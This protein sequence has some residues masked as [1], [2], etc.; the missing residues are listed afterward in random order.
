MILIIDADAHFCASIQKCFEREQ[1]MALAAFTGRDG[2]EMCRK[3]PV[4]VVILNQSLPDMPGDEVCKAILSKNEN[5][6]IV[7]VTEQPNFNAAVKAIRAGAF[8]CLAKPCKLKELTLTV[9]RAL[10]MIDMEIGTRDGEDHD[11]NEDTR[12]LLIDGGGLRETHRLIDLAASNDV[13]V[14]ITGETGTGKN[15]VAK[16]IHRLGA[17]R[18]KPFVCINCAALPE[19]L[20]E[21]E[22]FGYE[23]GAFT[24]AN[25]R[26]RGIFE[27]AEGGT[28]LLDE[29]G[30]MPIGL[31]SKLLDVLEEKRIWRLG[32]E[33]CRAVRV[34][35]I[36]AT[37]VDLEKELGRHF[38]TDLFYRL[39]VLRIHIPP[40]RDRPQDIPKLCR[41]L[42]SRTDSKLP[43]VSMSEDELQKL[44]EYSW[45]GNVRELKN[46][47]ERAVISQSE[48]AIKPSE[49]L[50]HFS[51]SVK[52]LKENQILRPPVACHKTPPFNPGMTP[53]SHCE[54]V[55][56]LKE[57][58]REYIL[59]TMRKNAG[60]YTQ[61]AK[62]LH[63]ALSTLKRKLKNYGLR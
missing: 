15:L 8:D 48:G 38:R 25:R 21:A 49:L 5:T 18:E 62:D 17:T 27:M 26:K 45:P 22:L 4:Q 52:S 39:S 9:A 23:K 13:S 14:L 42:L 61:T 11:D 19:N 41:H 56:P 24:G 63:I 10:R 43:R 34:R 12:S 51:A 35:V 28:L 33:S 57:I 31:Q 6:K 36:T 54:E 2:L 50:N 16:A 44:T 58:E 59:D 37:N 7:F 1:I 40:L 53:N 20:I 60:N 46:V 32:S 29:I 47:L 55:L 3:E 30:E